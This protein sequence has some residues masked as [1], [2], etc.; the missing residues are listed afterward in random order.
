MSTKNQNTSTKFMIHKK[1]NVG[2]LKERKL[3]HA[4]FVKSIK[5]S[6]TVSHMDTENYPPTQ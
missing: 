5:N 2:E 3:V 1:K 4:D 6:H